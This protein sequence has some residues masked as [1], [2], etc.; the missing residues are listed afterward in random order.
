ML[1]RG[2]ANEIGRVAALGAEAG[3][4]GAAVLALADSAAV[5]GHDT[6]GDRA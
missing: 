2:E 3:V 5:A 4:V 1:E 6:V